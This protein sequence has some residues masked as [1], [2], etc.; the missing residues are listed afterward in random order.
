MNAAAASLCAILS[1]VIVAGDHAPP[2]ED[3]SP[4]AILWY[5]PGSPR[6][7]DRNGI[8]RACC[9]CSTRVSDRF[10]TG[11]LWVT[12]EDKHFVCSVWRH[13]DAQ[14]SLSEDHE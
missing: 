14:I 3:C 12:G 4:N 9:P 5:P 10:D 1:T 11:T 13:D 7:I 2:E 6:W 8:V